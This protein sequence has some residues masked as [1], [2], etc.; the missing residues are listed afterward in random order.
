MQS[1]GLSRVFSNTTVQK[2]QFI[3]IF[4]SFKWESYKI[5]QPIMLLYHCKAAG[6][7]EKNSAGQQYTS[8]SCPAHPHD[9]Y[10]M[11]IYYHFTHCIMYSMHAVASVIFD[12]LRPNGL[13]PTSLLP[14]WDSP[15][16]NTEVGCHFLL[17]GIFLTQGSNPCLL[18]LLR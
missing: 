14:P 4:A 15:G 11:I 9:H 10:T 3:S 12:S 13:L 1:K 7:K 18:C 2:Y 8:L 5:S 17:Q 16:K 6:G